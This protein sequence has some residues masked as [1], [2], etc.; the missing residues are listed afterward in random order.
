MERG[1]KL[2]FRGAGQPGANTTSSRKKT[3][4]LL[5][6]LLSLGTLC[7]PL[8]VQ[9]FLLRCRRLPGARRRLGTSFLSFRFL[10]PVCSRSFSRRG[11][12]GVHILSEDGDKKIKIP[13]GPD[14]RRAFCAPGRAALSRQTQQPVSRKHATKVTH[15]KPNL[16]RAFLAIA[17]EPS[18][19]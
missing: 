17:A 6:S 9:G 15:G 13:R 19:Y 10:F 1:S 5:R 18:T 2:V 14:N 7:T 16:L 4:E 8:H 3:Q 11:K 12:E